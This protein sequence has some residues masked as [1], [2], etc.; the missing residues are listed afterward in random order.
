MS[1]I[2]RRTSI[3]LTCALVALATVNSKAQTFTTLATLKTTQGS[4]PFSPLVQGRDGNFYG[5]AHNG[6]THGWGSVFRVTPSGSVTVLYNF[7]AQTS[8]ADGA[9]P[10]PIILATDGN[11]Y[12]VTSAGGNFCSPTSN[13][14]G[15]GTAFK[16][17]PKGAFNVIHSFDGTDG[18]APNG[19][20]EGADRNFYGTAFTGGSSAICELCGTVFRMTPAGTITIM[21]NFRGGDGQN[22]VGLVQGADGSLYGSTYGGGKNNPGFCQP[23]FGCGT[24]FKMTTSGAFISL[25]SFDVTD[26]AILYAPVAQAEDGA[27]YGSTFYG[28]SI[29]NGDNGTI[30]SITS[31]GHFE[32]VYQ[33]SGIGA[34]PITGL[35]PATDGKLYGTIYEGGVCGVGDLYSMSLDRVFNQFVNCA[36]GGPDNV[37]QFTNGIFYGEDGSVIYSFDNGLGPFISFVLPAGKPGQTAQILGQGLA[38]TTSVTFNGVAATSFKVDSDTYMTAVVPSGATTGTVLVT[39]PSG[40]LTSNANFRIGK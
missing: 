21:H 3:L 15:C 19:L 25:H 8:C 20:I 35:I 17:S 1:L 2:N 11:F 32:S 31:N 34:N 30:F 33:F 36:Y 6:G 24:V 10:G 26:G 4:S 29:N 13:P 22:P 14:P 18:V 37:A 39:T 16:I 5:T 28:S 7:C 23:Y 9:V 12:G 38:G 27:F 40:T